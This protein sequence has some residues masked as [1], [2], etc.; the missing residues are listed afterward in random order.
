MFHR[1]SQRSDMFGHQSQVAPPDRGQA[2]TVQTH[3][4]IVAAAR[5]IDLL[6]S[7]GKSRNEIE[8]RLAALDEAACGRRQT[9]SRI[10]ADQVLIWYDAVAPD[11]ARALL[12]DALFHHIATCQVRGIRDA[13]GS[14]RRH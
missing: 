2:A 12:R 5:D 9:S 10:V 1:P 14:S 7:A 13:A 6:A 3:M 4:M 11:R 8:R